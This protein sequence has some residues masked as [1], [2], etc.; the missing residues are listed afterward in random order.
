MTYSSRTDAPD[1]SWADTGADDP[2]PMRHSGMDGHE[3]ENYDPAAL[4]AELP[5][6]D[7]TA[8]APSQA[9]F[10]DIGARPEWH[11]A[12]TPGPVAAA[13]VAVTDAVQAAVDADRRERALG[14]EEAQAQRE[15]AARVRSATANGKSVKASAGRDWAA[16]RRHLA[17]VAAGHRERARQCRATYETSV[18]EHRAA[19]TAQLVES[20]PAART[21][22]LA[23]L[24]EAGDRVE[25]LLAAASAAQALLLA[26]GGSVVSLPVLQVRRF[27]EA[28]QALAVEIEGS[29]QL[30]GVDL[31]RPPMEP[32]WAE[33][34][35]IGVMLLHGV[36]DSSTHWLAE[37]EAREGFALTSFTQGAAL[38]RPP[39]EATQW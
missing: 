33:R 11:A 38:G 5:P 29:P 4:A 39:S 2:R 25:R 9:N 3:P 8:V 31:V 14:G 1:T 30:G 12:S 23:A 19:W 26:P 24:A 34:Q 20:L 28:V 36:I 18:L 7:G 21:S 27:C 16:E 37:L 17:A 13:W 35:S 22:A 32:T 10:D 6:R 15:E